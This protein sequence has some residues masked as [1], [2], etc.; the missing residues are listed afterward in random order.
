MDRIIT[1]TEANQKFSKMLRDVARGDNF[2]VTSR[3]QPVARVI[4]PVHQTTTR[5]DVEAFHDYLRSLPRRTGKWRREDLY[6]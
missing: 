4:A 3:G 2:T 5:E 1:S 6:D